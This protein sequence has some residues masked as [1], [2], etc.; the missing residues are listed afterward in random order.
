MLFFRTQLLKTF[1]AF[2][3][4]LQQLLCIIYS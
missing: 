1:F 2:S 4:V 3:L